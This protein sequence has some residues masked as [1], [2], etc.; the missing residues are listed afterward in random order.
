MCPPSEV[1]SPLCEVDGDRNIAD[2]CHEHNNC[3]PGL[4]GSGQVDAC[5]RNIK[6]LRADVEDHRRQ[7][8]LD[9]VGACTTGIQQRLQWCQGH[10]QYFLTV[11]TFNV[12]TAGCEDAVLGDPGSHFTENALHVNGL[13]SQW[14]TYL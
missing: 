13:S 7:N 11:K 2:K 4:Q 8:A 6:N 12:T 5:C 9:G 14:R 3:N 1:A 10:V